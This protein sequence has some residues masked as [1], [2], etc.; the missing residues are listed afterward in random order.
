M[1]YLLPTL[2]LV[3]ICQVILTGT[4]IGQTSNKN[5]SPIPVKEVS[6]SATLTQDEMGIL[7]AEIE[8]L[9]GENYQHAIKV[10]EQAGQKA[11][12][13]LNW[14]VG[15]ATFFGFIILIV[16]FTLGKNIFDLL[17]EL[18]AHAKAAKKSAQVIEGLATKAQQKGEQLTAEISQIQ[19]LKEE[20]THSKDKTKEQ[21]LKLTN[22]INQ[23]QG[24]ISD[25]QSLKNSATLVSGA[26]LAY[27]PY[28]TVNVVEPIGP[29]TLDLT[30]K[31]KKCGTPLPL[32]TE[33]YTSYG[34]PDICFACKMR[35]KDS[36]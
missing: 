1:K 32:N 14:L 36:G 35:A 28:G 18:R 16:T 15:L 11:D 17:N 25:I 10:A 31:C 7:K 27:P 23:A 8:K 26:T 30:K 34:D 9:R 13:L 12:R 5:G 2:I 4:V 3:F 24:T 6:S 21:E 22:L 29:S 19:S 20:L 33:G